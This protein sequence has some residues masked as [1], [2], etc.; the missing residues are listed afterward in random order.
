MAPERWLKVKE[1]F[2]AALELG[3]GE[4]TAFLSAACT[5]D[6]S[7]REE[8]ERLLDSYEQD[9][10][11]M[12][13][14][15]IASAAHSLLEG[16]AALLI[17]KSIGPYQIVREIGRGGMGEV[18]LAEDSRLGRLVALKL[19]PTFLSADEDRLARFKQEARIASALNH[20]NILTIYEIGQLD[21]RQFIAAEFIEGATL[22]E[23]MKT[24]DVTLVE[25]LE[26]A[27]QVADALAAAHQAGIVHRDIKP[28]N[29]MVRHDGYVKVLDFG[30][31]KLTEK[32]TGTGTADSMETTRDLVRTGIG[33]VMGTVIYMSP[34][35]TRGL[36]VDARSDVWSLGVVLYEMIGGKAPFEGETNSDVV[37]AILEREPTP[38]SQL[39]PEIP[40]ELPP[41]IGKALCKDKERR[42]QTARELGVDLRQLQSSVSALP[43][44]K[45]SRL[46]TQQS[47]ARET[48]PGSG[49]HG[50]PIMKALATISALI[51]RPRFVISAAIVAAAVGIVLVWSA[52]NRPGVGIPHRPSPEAASWYDRGT[53]EMRDGAY[54]QA[55][56]AFERAV[57]ID[58][59]YALAHARLGE[60]WSELDYTDKA[61]DELLRAN[62]L[63][64]DR[65]ALAPLDALYLQGFIDTLSRNFAGA[66]ENYRKISERVPDKDKK[67][68]Y[69]DL[70]WAYEKNEDIDGAVA[71]YQQ[72]VRLD[73]EYPTPFL[74]LGVL[75]G[76]QQALKEA[77]EAFKKAETLYQA[78]S[79]FEGVGEV[80]Y[81]KGLHLNFL[82]RL[83]EARLELEKALET[84]HTS[85][86]IYQQV[87]AALELS[88][89]LAAE[90][91][92]EQAEKFARDGIEVA[93]DKGLGELTTNGLID[94]GQAF[95]MKGDYGEAEKYFGQALDNAR[96]YGQRSKEATA[97]LCFGSLRIQQRN[98]DEASQFLEQALAFF[99]PG[100]Y[101]RQTSNVNTLRGR[102]YRQKGDYEAALGAF[103]Q[104]LQQAQDVGD[105]SQIA[106]SYAE[107]GTVLL[108]QEQY[109]EALKNYDQSYQLRKS[110]NP[111]TAYDLGRRAEALWPLGHYAEA[112]AALDDASSLSD[113]AGDKQLSAYVLQIRADMAL[114]QLNFPESKQAAQKA[115]EMAGNRF[116]SIAVSVRSALGL[117]HVRSGSI[118]PGRL[119]CEQSAERAKALGD[120]QL[121]SVSLLALAE[122]VL[123]S[124]DTRL[125]LENALMAQERF[126][127]FAQRESEWRAWLI[128]ARASRLP[129]PAA[130]PQYASNAETSLAKLEQQWGSPAFSGYQ[131]RPDIRRFREQLTQLLSK[132]K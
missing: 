51:R 45:L 16:Q 52:V 89:V 85:N 118:R 46:S 101:G 59:R 55:S 17:G 67:Y 30:L 91:S 73:S 93:R 90:G 111:S 56:K 57:E 122:A 36:T 131:A 35:Q 84:A 25:A 20:P 11:F 94:L 28:E 119:L 63:V 120:P 14:P 1:L 40:A 126:A 132:T 78:Q 117:A 103:R 6:R 7:L 32:F 53:A 15:A 3:A 66:A 44:S 48:A 108:M 54:F 68:A 116:P 47:I 60:A 69:V 50:S 127:R 29:I 96:R 2:E 79:N 88:S 87:R 4:R 75:Y 26:I 49:E 95:L 82:D 64:P 129:D 123:E 37:V 21:G 109:E 121:I 5:E 110:S 41:I 61:K 62:A 33:R 27:S 71:A 8:V 106:R 92:T 105:Q 13:S 100:G 99:K 80:L 74:R 97:Q 42:Y 83:E 58:D 39:C 24:G 38:L 70:G 81:Q 12:E 102:A 9:R 124:G 114:S 104:V 86:N 98:P 65:S 23:R 128:A 34:E 125:A 43:G 10:N 77:E 115:L 19:L 107:I 76:R 72:A 31:A 113:R 18:Y 22:R 112:L 130:T